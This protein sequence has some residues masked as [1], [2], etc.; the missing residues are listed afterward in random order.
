MEEKLSSM[1]SAP[2]RPIAVGRQLPVNENVIMHPQNGRRVFPWG[3]C[4]GVKV[5]GA[6]SSVHFGSVH[7]RSQPWSVRTSRSFRNRPVNTLS[8]ISRIY[9]CVIYGV[10]DLVT[11]I[12]LVF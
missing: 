5:N 10:C 11:L 7:K 1:R 3:S 12:V 4:K 2:A 8:V 9:S 6:M